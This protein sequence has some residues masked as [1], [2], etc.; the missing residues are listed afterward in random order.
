MRKKNGW[1]LGTML[2]LLGVLLL[3]GLIAAYYIY[4]LYTGI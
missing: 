1:G 4:I 3:F 2:A